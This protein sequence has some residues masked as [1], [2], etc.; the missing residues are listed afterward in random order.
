MVDFGFAVEVMGLAMGLMTGR[1][2]A[3]IA[4]AVTEE[5]ASVLYKHAIAVEPA[6]RVRR[7]G[8]LKVKRVGAMVS[9]TEL[10]G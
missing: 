4:L 5:R 9:R 6:I 8:P 1:I 2:A 10:G 7:R 3:R